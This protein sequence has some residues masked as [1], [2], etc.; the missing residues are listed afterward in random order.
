MSAR[1]LL[2]VLEA[3]GVRL[4]LADDDLRFQTRA[5]VSIAPFRAHIASH[6]PAIMAELLKARIIEAVTV[7][8]ARFDRA[9]YDRLV[10][11]W[12]ALDGLDAAGIA[13]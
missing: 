2:A 11:Q 10:A 9:E 7:D 8:P 1:A 3:A 6:K 12:E 4:S 13:S 5:G